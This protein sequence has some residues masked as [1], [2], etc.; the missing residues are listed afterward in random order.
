[1]YCCS[2]TCAPKYDETHEHLHHRVEERRGG[3][4]RRLGHRLQAVAPEDQELDVRLGL[5]GGRAGRAVEEA[6]LTEE[7]EGLDAHQHLLDLAR[8]GLRDEHGPAPHDEH[9][10]AAIAF[11]E[12]DLMPPQ[13]ALAQPLGYHGEIGIGEGLE[14]TNLAQEREGFGR[15]LH[16]GWTRG[17]G[18]HAAD[19][20]AAERVPPLG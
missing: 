3:V 16:D 1:M 7:V 14:H 4:R 11:T 20:A 18:G 12:E 19:E 15:R 10:V 6:H 5:R 9:L 8:D 2:A 17:L 13:V